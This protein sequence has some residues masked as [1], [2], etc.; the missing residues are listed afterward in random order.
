MKDELTNILISV[1]ENHISVNNAKVLIE[2]LYAPYKGKNINIV[3]FQKEKDP[4]KFKFPVKFILSVIKTF[5][6]IPNL[7]IKQLESVDLKNLSKVVSV[8]IEENITGE[9]LE[10]ET[11]DHNIIKVSIE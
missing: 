2:G 11:D 7:G 8:A 6:T 9:I 1:K 4:I 3:V 10:M 5:G